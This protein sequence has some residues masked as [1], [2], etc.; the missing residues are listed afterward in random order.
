MLWARSRIV[1]GSLCAGVLATTLGAGATARATPDGEEEPVRLTYRAPD[2]CPDE[3]DFVARLRARTSRARMAWPG[4]PART[5]DVAI[6]AGPPPSGSVAVLEP[7][8]PMGTRRVQ[9]DTCADV[10]DALALVIALSVDPHASLAPVTPVA[11]L[12]AAP[13]SSSATPE[14]ASSALPPAG[15]ESP[16]PSSPPRAELFAGVDLA[17]TSGV[18]PSALVSG[19]PYIG[20]RAN[21]A[22]A[23][24]PS[25]RLAF[26]SATSDAQVLSAGSADFAWTA[27]RF[28]VCPVAWGGRLLRL[29]ACA[30]LEAGAL[31]VAARDVPLPETRVRPWLA[32]GPLARAEWVFLQPVFLEAEIGLLLRPTNDRFYFQPDTTVYRVP[33][34][35]TSGAIGV[36]AHFL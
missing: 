8:F 16:P 19:S 31:R 11:T 30:R 26:V 15:K 18:A 1:R 36:G 33:L 2:G 21:A 10:A 13:P 7:D 20:W 9:A 29:T 4:E 27:G 32:T 23:F 14:P 35:A 17:V 24:D 12:P 6:D 5:F 28:D 34:F 25:L 22:G 3:A